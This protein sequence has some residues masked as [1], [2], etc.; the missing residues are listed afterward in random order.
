MANAR[1]HQLEMLSALDR[2][3]AFDGCMEARGYSL[4]KL[5]P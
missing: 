3:R 5:A 2:Q 1:L 4:Q